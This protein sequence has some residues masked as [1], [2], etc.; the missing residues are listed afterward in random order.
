MTEADPDNRSERTR[1]RRQA[2]FI[3]LSAAPFGVT[4]GIAAVEAGLSVAQAMGFSVLVFAGSAQFAAVSVLGDGGTVAAAVIAGLLLN[5]RSLA[6]G[7]ALAPALRGTWPWRA[8]V[9]QLMIDE[10]T[11]VGTAQSTKSL[12][13]Y[14]YLAAG[15]AVFVVWNASTLLGAAVLSSSGDLVENLGLDAAIPAV[16]LALVWPRLAD[17]TQRRLAVAGAAVAL[18]LSPFTAAGIPILASAGVVVLARG[19]LRG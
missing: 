10:S 19:E 3:A 18:L 1:V 16:F 2:I 13:R 5:L 12:R 8:L 17:P 14:G 9:S 7:V 4:F 6:F 11:A 15:V